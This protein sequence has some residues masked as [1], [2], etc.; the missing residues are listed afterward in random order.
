MIFSLCFAALVANA[1]N[2]FD[3]GVWKDIITGENPHKNVERICK[4]L[5]KT[6]A[7]IQTENFRMM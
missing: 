3:A 5:K 6:G 1:E 4:F 2:D 7:T